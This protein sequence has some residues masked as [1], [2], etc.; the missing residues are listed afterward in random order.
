M[1]RSIH[2]IIAATAAG[3]ITLAAIPLFAQTGTG[4]SEGQS[5]FGDWRA[6]RPGMR[7]LIKPQDL[8]APDLAAVRQVIPSGS[9][10][11]P[12]SKSQSSQMALKSTCLPPVSRRRASSAPR[13]TATCSSPR[14]RAGR[15]RVLR[16]NGGTAGQPAT[17]ASGLSGAVRHRVLSA[18]PNPEWVYIGNTDSVVRFPYRNGDLDGAWRRRNHRPRNCRSAAIAPATS[19]SHRTARPCMSRSDPAP[20]SPRNGQAQ[21]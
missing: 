15:I 3:I 21:R 4:R 5:A 1:R 16:A 7:R 11:A 14:A 10:A 19:C 6:D 13:R 9:C 20:T 2:A 8:P 17:F 12:T 18:G